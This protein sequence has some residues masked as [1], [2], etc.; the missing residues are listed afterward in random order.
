[1]DIIST[2]ENTKAALEELGFYVLPS[3]ANFLFARH[4]QFS[5]EGLYQELKKRGILV[6]HF[7]NPRIREYL[8][9]TIGTPEQMVIL[10]D[11]LKSILSGG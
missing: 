8:R 7:S 10:Q 2:R 3:K 11:T 1:M 9:I 5:G 6:R 4:D